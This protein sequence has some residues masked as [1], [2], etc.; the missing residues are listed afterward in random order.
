[1]RAKPDGF[2]I[3][4][5]ETLDA[6]AVSRIASYTMSSYTY[7]YQQKYGSTEVDPQ[8]VVLTHV[9]VLA[10]GKSVRL[11]CSGL[12]EG[13]VHELAANGV[14]ALRGASLEKPEAYYTLNRRPR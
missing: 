1:M 10:D 14:R 7:W 11:H 9:T 8:P 2:V 4:F 3:E 12:R 13:Y 6:A 5:T